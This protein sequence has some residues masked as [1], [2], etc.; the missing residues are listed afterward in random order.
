[1]RSG[2]AK[3]RASIS[4]PLPKGGNHVSYWG[5]RAISVTP[6]AVCANSVQLV[7]LVQVTIDNIQ[8][9]EYALHMNY[10]TVMVDVDKTLVYDTLGMPVGPTSIE[11]IYTNGPITVTPHAANIELVRI[12]YKLGYEVIVWS[13]TGEDW[14]RLIVEAVGL[15]KEVSL[16]LTKPLYYFDDEDCGKWMGT[17]VWKD[18]EN[19]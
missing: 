11:V 16:C 7:Q 4:S 1:V 9:K 19:E 8:G 3:L 14:A 18:F 6:I 10:K 5:N 17:R 13:K 2:C 15:Q 12:F